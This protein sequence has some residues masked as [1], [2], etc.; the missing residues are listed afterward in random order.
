MKRASSIAL[1]K[2]YCMELKKSEVYGKD[3][4]FM[5]Y[6][7]AIEPDDAI[8]LTPSGEEFNLGWS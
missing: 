5:S 3:K 8:A 6:K 7:R 1:C 4:V 2:F